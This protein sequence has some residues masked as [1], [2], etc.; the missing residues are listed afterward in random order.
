VPDGIYGISIFQGADVMYIGSLFYPPVSITIYCLAGGTL[1]MNSQKSTHSGHRA[2]MRERFFNTGGSGFEAHELLELALFAAIPKRDVNP[3]AHQLLDHFG[4]LSNVFSASEQ[5]LMQVPGI[6]EGTARL[7]AALG[8]AVHYFGSEWSKG[9]RTLQNVASVLYH[10][11]TKFPPTQMRDLICLF[12]SA[13]GSLMTTR[14]FPGRINE[15]PVLRSI[16]S[17]ALKLH[18]HSIV[19]ATRSFS[20]LSAPCEN[21]LQNI[22]RLISTLN[23]VNIY[24]VDYLFLSG[25]SVFSMR[26][27]DMLND[28]RNSMHENLPRWYDW[29][30]P[31]SFF[32][33]VNDW[34]EIAT[35]QLERF[36]SAGSCPLPSFF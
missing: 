32:H 35:Q 14:L 21:D 28:G 5:E 22:E 6:G 18:T 20:P 9:N 10:I 19:I 33:S 2:R 17:E 15:P 23:D 8:S 27:A 25:D 31:L 3:L 13:N 11:R 36:L 30:L 34:Y 24:T 26:A 16:I 7:I 12:E 29:L 1:A 4:S